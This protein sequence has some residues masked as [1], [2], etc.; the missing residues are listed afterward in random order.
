MVASTNPVWIQT[1]F[2]MLKG[3]FESVVLQTNIQKTVG[4]VCQP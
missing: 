4:V 3:L 1:T 2:D